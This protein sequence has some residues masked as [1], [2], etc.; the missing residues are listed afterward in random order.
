MQIQ[1]EKTLDVEVVERQLA[2]LWKQMAGG[3]SPG[4][5]AEDD[6]F[7]VMR[8]RVANLLVYVGQE[9]SLTEVDGII[10]ELTA[11]HPSRVLLML[12]E[13]KKADRDIEMSVE[14]FCQTDKRTGAKR[15]CC[16]E[17]TL[18]ARG[19]FVA[20]LPS[21]ALPLVVPDLTTF[22]WWR[23]ALASDNESS[24]KVFD[25]LLLASD[26]LVVDSAEFG[27]PQ[28]DL[29]ALNKL[30]NTKDYA[31]VGI[32][33]LNWARLT[34]WRALLAGFYDVP[35]YQPLLD[36]VDTVRIDYLAGQPAQT[37]SG[38]DEHPIGDAAIGTPLASAPSAEVAPQALLI[39]GWLASRL[40]W[41]LATDQPRQESDQTVVFNFSGKDRGISPTPGSPARQP[42]W[43]GTV[44]EGVAPRAIKLELNR[45]VRAD[46]KP[47][48]LV[49]VELQSNSG[50]PASFAVAR[51]A[52]S[53]HLTTEA[54]VDGD[55]QHGRVVPVR[56]RSAAQLL[57]REMEILCND[58]IYQEA[59]AMAARMIDHSR[60][61]SSY[62]SVNLLANGDTR[63]FA[64][65]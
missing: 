46:G 15:L 3:V 2:E 51:S 24:D 55:V 25:A 61:P 63:G 26:R 59:I 30:F 56:N 62:D 34:S 37:K 4:V 8:A 27:E 23:D 53:L 49:R 29:L 32:S 52:D 28:S 65:S 5:G 54:R 58:Q 50:Q 39:A 57:G 19:N 9:S 36:R 31:H 12:G 11:I 44:R 14:T 38:Q 40:G 41:N 43:G 10:A 6:Q 1:L 17:V 42:R 45:V 16:E 47:G 13:K 60:S 35:T 18:T 64:K 22:L 20:E 21:A 48:R 7:A 33:D